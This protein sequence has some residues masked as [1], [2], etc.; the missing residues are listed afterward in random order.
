M[1]VSFHPKNIAQ[2][3][4]TFTGVLGAGAVAWCGATGGHLSDPNTWVPAVII[5]VMGA[6]LKVS[7]GGNDEKAGSNPSSGH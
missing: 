2:I 6:C 3:E 4:S 7:Q 5:A 1:Q